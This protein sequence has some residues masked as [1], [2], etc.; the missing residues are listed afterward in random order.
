MV[1]TYFVSRREFYTKNLKIDTRLL[2]SIMYIGKTW[3]PFLR[4]KL[5]IFEP[6]SLFGW[7][8]WPRKWLHQKFTYSF[9]A[10]VKKMAD[11]SQFIL[12]L[13][14]KFP[15][16]KPVAARWEDINSHNDP[17]KSSAHREPDMR[18]CAFFL[19]SSVEDQPTFMVAVSVAFVLKYWRWRCF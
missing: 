13:T 12:S 5:P 4:P 9:S 18:G 2:K 1:W 14:L 17:I 8:Q 6:I 3:H 10:F 11:Y 19:V 7:P 15:H 16:K